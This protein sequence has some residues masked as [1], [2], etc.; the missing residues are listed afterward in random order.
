[1]VVLLARFHLG[2][3]SENHEELV[4][5][6]HR[7]G[8]HPNRRTLHNR[9]V[10]YVPNTAPTAELA[11][12][13]AANPAVEHVE[14]VTA[15]PP[16]VS[17]SST[18][19]PT[20]VRINRTVS[21]SPGEFVV[22]AGPCAVESPDQL[23]TIA[24]EV[25]RSGATVLRGGVFKPRTSPYSFQGLGERGLSLLAAAA[26]AT[27]LPVVTEVTDVAHVQRTAEV[28][29]ILQVGTRNAQNFSL[30]KEVA[31]A[32]RPVLL[33]RGFGCTVDEWLH[34]AEY[35]LNEGNADV[36]L[37]ERGIRTFEGATRFTLDISAVALVKHLSH[38][39]VVVDP[40]H[41]S[42]RRELVEPLALAAAAAGADGILVDVHH[43]GAAA[44]CDGDQALAP[45][46]FSHLTNRL[47]ALRTGLAAAP[48]ANLLVS[49]RE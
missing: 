3:T 9:T 11:A 36:V 17:A 34:A 31:L 45:D 21:F 2:T 24:H 27:G 15:T 7:R 39:P 1:M 25:A 12:F 43:E 26:E 48:E 4:N 30:L 20:T 28:A 44:L 29:D 35:V 5:A 22:M 37:C 8:Y 46:Q 18:G 13:L 42:G 41:A 38:L 40:S 6:L 14:D 47:R 49:A 23:A 33:K 19:A 16:L 32:G 10:V